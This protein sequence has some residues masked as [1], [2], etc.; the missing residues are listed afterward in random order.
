MVVGGGGGAL[1]R[2]RR[3]GG[4]GERV[5]GEGGGRGVF[6]RER[7]CNVFSCDPAAHTTSALLCWHEWLLTRHLFMMPS[8]I[9]NDCHSYANLPMH[10]ITDCV[11]FCPG[12]SH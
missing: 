11:V 12:C 2:A 9:G 8:Q 10:I 5:R 4:G 7:I 1:R 3:V 6:G